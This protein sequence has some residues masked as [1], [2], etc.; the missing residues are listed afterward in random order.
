M[1]VAHVDPLEQ[2][3]AAVRANDPSLLQQVL[4]RHPELT[5]RLDDAL[6]G[7]AFG[8]TALL[9]AVDRGNRDMI[10][11]LLRAG[12]DINA[13][14]HWWAGSFGVL[15]NDGDLAPFLIER[16]ATVDI[17]AAARLGLLADVERLVSANHALVHA[18]GGDGQTPLHVAASIEIAKYLLDHG[19]D[20]NARDIDHESTPAQYLVRAR[21]EVVRYLIERGAHSDILMAAA[22]GD[23]TR[24]RDYLAADPESIRTSVSEAY[25][26]KQDP[27]SAGTIYIWTLGAHK[28]A[29]H[30]AREF[31]HGEVFQLLMDRT[32]DGLKL[33]IACELGDERTCRALVAQHPDLARTL[34]DQERGRLA[35]A[36]QDENMEGVRLMLE[37]GWPV[38]VR[39]QHGATPLHWAAWHGN[40]NIVRD[41]LQHHPTLD[42]ADEEFGGTPASWAIYGS[43]HGWHPKRG[44][45]ARTV[46][47]LLDAGATPPPG[48]RADVAMSDAVREVLRQRG[49]I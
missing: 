1:D 17:H 36:A 11:V 3:A 12:A 32:P 43:V 45:Y 47:M 15:D 29:H 38:N 22:L 30:V 8:A 42:V 10:E 46:E 24:V 44:D 20:V 14:S 21:Q 18:R 31:G 40:G 6:P 48:V 34:G 16:G 28:M 26:P 33:A 5:S 49:L 9:A 41:L 2:L 37:A 35:I 7:S 13:R 25:F 19:A 23:L 39:G 27:R 4:E